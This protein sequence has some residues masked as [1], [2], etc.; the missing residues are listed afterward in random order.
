MQVD[1]R[2]KELYKADGVIRKLY[3]DFYHSGEEAP[4]LTLEGVDQI[5]GGSMKITES[6]SSSENL[7]FGSCEASQLE[8]R[9]IN[10]EEKDILGARL[11]AYQTLQGLYPSE[12]VYPAEDIYP[13]GYVMPFGTY[14]VQ[15]A[16]RQT[17]GRY[18]DLLALD[19][20]CLFDVDVVEW[21]NALP[22]PLT[23]R[24]FRARLCA[25]IGVTEHVPDYL[26]NDNML[27]EKTIDTAEL[28]GRDVLIACEQINGAFGHFDRNGV[29]Q[30]VVI[31]PNILL[32]PSE[33]L[34]PS[35]ELFPGTIPEGDTEFYD[36]I[37]ESY[38]CISC[39]VEEYMVQPIDTVH[40]RQEEGDIGAIYG[41][42]ENCYI[43]EDNFLVYGKTAAELEHIAAGIHSMIT[44]F[45][46]VPYE[47]RG[48]GLPYLEVGS[49]VWLQREGTAT[50]I[51]KR[52]LAGTS[53]LK[54]DYSATGEE[55]RGVENNVNTEIIQLKGR[56]AILK[57]TVDEVS[58]AVTNLESQTV[59]QFKI[60]SD[61]ITSEVTRAK[62]MENE[63]SSKITQQAGLIDMKVS[64]GEVSSQISMESGQVYI[65]SNR[66]VV[67]STNFKL[68]SS[69]NATFSG[70]VT[71]A[72]ISGSRISGTEIE[73]TTITGGS[74]S[75]A[76]F[77]GGTIAVGVFYADESEAQIGDWYVSADGS[78]IFA[79]SD[80]S[81]S[82][83]T[84]QGGPFGSY[85]VLK[86]T[87]KSGTTIVSDHHVET[88]VINGTV[89]VVTPAVD[90]YDPDDPR[91]SSFYDIE[92]GRSWWGGDSITDIVRELWESCDG[93]SDERAKKNIE[94]IDSAEAM[95]F[96]MNARPVT[97]Q[98]KRD[99]KWSAGFI[100]QEIESC[101]DEMGIYYPLVGNDSKTGYYKVDYRTY[102]PLLVAAVQHLQ[103]Q[104]SKLRGE[105]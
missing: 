12:D 32:Y 11:V 51:M 75:G 47:Y 84:A 79:S 13:D 55:L 37:L 36:E 15:S 39:R 49:L 100:A 94:N 26:P 19:Q 17:N 1:E 74:I 14:I 10:I 23:L 61:Q 101:M 87:S 93:V 72:T 76:S 66:L 89:R 68:D 91:Y 67:D 77:D 43:V 22:F 30:H 73:G 65:G 42:G 45:K 71:G 70:N 4:F 31:E 35:E 18:R 27:V 5:L 3:L 20:M 41:N 34:Y 8:V 40:I 59:A 16:P 104:I 21:Y 60:L 96:L 90:G 86:L 82:F 56:S 105:E 78:N 52:T 29:L 44:G 98:Y 38:L 53:A 9:V 63:L 88:P 46:Y 62:G 69:G 64:K 24:E 50:Y 95:T 103:M 102:T 92:L 97:F 48:K 7:E 57:K 58:V 99:G 6:L 54:D 85:A 81:V 80:G 2:L 25:H 33:Y 28:I 83:Q